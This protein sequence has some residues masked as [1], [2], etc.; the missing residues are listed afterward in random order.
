MIGSKYMLAVSLRSLGKHDARKLPSAGDPPRATAIYFRG[1]DA[2]P[3]ENGKSIGEKS[4]NV[5]RGGRC[6]T[7]A[8]PSAG[9]G[10]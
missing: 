8:L 10:L 1:G 9:F 4:L 3:E 7:A 6:R 2:I 5:F